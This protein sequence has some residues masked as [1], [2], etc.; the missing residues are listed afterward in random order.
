MLFIQQEEV[1]GG[2]VV[3]FENLH[4]V[5]LNFSRLFHDTFVFIGEGTIEKAFPFRIC[6]G[7]VI[8][9]FKLLAQIKD[10]PSLVSDAD[11]FIPLR[12]KLPDKFALHLSF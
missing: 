4:I 12:R 6:E 9:R 1:P 10:Q 2:A 11:L 3:P 8:E 7:V 5:V